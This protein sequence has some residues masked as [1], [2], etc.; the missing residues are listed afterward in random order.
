MGFGDWLS[1]AGSAVDKFLGGTGG[2]PIPVGTQQTMT[3]DE[4][5]MPPMVSET[6]SV[7]APIEP[8]MP[9]NVSVVTDSKDQSGEYRPISTDTSAS[10]TQ[11][12][13]ESYVAYTEPKEIDRVDYT[14]MKDIGDS[15]T[16]E[17]I[18][19]G[20]SPEQ[21]TAMQR[22]IAKEAGN[23]RAELYYQN[24]YDKAMQSKLALSSEYHHTAQESGLP[25]A[26]NPFEYTG[27]LAKMAIH[28]SQGVSNVAGTGLIPQF[29]GSLVEDANIVTKAAR[30]GEMGDYKNLGKPF[31]SATGILSLE[32][33]QDIGRRA[34]TSPLN[35]FGWEVKEDAMAKFTPELK[36]SSGFDLF[37]R[38]A[39]SDES[40]KAYPELL[41]PDYMASIT[42]G[43]KLVGR[44]K[45]DVKSVSGLVV[46][47]GGTPTNEIIG[48]TVA[49]VKKG[50]TS[51]GE[52]AG[53]SSDINQY[54][55]PEDV[56]SK[57]ST[58]STKI[59][60]KGTEMVGVIS[61]EKLAGF[62]EPEPY[63][64]VADKTMYDTGIW[65]RGTTI[66]ETKIGG[67]FGSGETMGGLTLQKIGIYGPP[68]GP[69]G[70]YFNPRKARKSAPVIKRKLTHKVA[71]PKIFNLEALNDNI[72]PKS[73]GK[74]MLEFKVGSL[75][76]VVDSM[77]AQKDLKNIIKIN[78]ADKIKPMK[79]I[80]TTVT[81]PN[82]KFTKGR[83]V[84]G[85]I[86]N[87]VKNITNPIKAIK[88]VKIKR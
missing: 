74:G 54:L 8:V 68:S 56:I 13:S 15:K 60:T 43:T 9:A 32:E 87:I 22:D 53:G 86:N 79:G 45:D 18:K 28:K 46:Q 41:T 57:T 44:S 72:M 23:T 21:A 40:K 80:S 34:A 26:P 70:T 85:N 6:Q 65:S 82:L 58:P 2:E 12:F 33:Q 24:E 42:S 66:G 47:M 37:Y 52:K 71:D 64:S 51:V 76:K 36:K 3:T 84:S 78:K 27:D 4:Y 38:E 7:S 75:N 77:G 20:Y 59:E 16:Q 67:R 10:S 25:Q 63:K 39:K 55:L 5:A 30:T 73:L 83:D 69:R 17:L 61:K 49:T 35:K 11:K 48:D 88:N 62:S 14:K 19:H 29:K 31:S 81:V 1:G 50:T